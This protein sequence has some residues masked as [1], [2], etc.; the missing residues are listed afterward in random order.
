V[1]DPSETE[2]EKFWF[3]PFGVG[4]NYPLT[5]SYI[6][7]SGGDE[8]NGSRAWGRT[9]PWMYPGWNSLSATTDLAMR[10]EGEIIPA[11]GALLPLAAMMVLSTSTRQ[12][13]SG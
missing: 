4:Q 6:G 9:I 2:N 1:L 7:T 5:R 10:L 3:S 13:R 12:R 11:P 8:V